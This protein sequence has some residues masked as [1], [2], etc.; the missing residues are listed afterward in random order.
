[1][2]ELR[3]VIQ[4]SIWEPNK[5]DFHLIDSLK[6]MLRGM[7]T[8][9]LVTAILIVLVVILNNYTKKK[10]EKEEKAKETEIENES[11]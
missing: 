9:F 7:L 5:E 3:N 6:I 11:Y 10:K 2:F 8:I 4:S 1:M